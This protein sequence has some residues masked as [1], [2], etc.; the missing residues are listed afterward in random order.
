MSLAEERLALAQVIHDSFYAM[1]AG[2]FPD[3]A[4]R[5]GPNGGDMQLASDIQE[6]GFSLEHAR[7]VMRRYMGWYHY[8]PEDSW[9]LQRDMCIALGIEEPEDDW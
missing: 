9:R 2:E 4:N 7:D 5:E 6:A 1:Q 3:P 8:S